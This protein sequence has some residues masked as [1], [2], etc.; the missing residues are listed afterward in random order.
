MSAEESEQQ[1]FTRHLFRT[2]CTCPTKLYYKANPATY[3]EQRNIWPFIAHIRYNKRQLRLLLQRLYP[4]G[5]AVESRAYHDAAEET[6]R[7]LKQN[8]VV[9]FNSTFLHELFAVR[10]PVLEKEGRRVRVYNLQSKVFDPDRHSLSDRNGRIHSRWRKYLRDFSFQLF[11]I[12][13]QFPEWRLEGYLVM[14]DKRGTAAVD[15]LDQ[16]LAAGEPVERDGLS[17]LLAFVPA[18][19]Q[20]EALWEGKEPLFE[21]GNAP[22]GMESL[23]FEEVVCQSARW[24]AGGDKIVTPLG[25]KCANCEYRVDSDKLRKGEKS[26]FE[27]CWQHILENRD[28]E[29][30]IFDLIGAGNGQL[31]EDR[32]FLQQEISLNDKVTPREIAESE[33]RITDLHRRILQVAQARGEPV[34]REIVKP[35]LFRELEKWQYPLHFLDFE[36]GSFAVPLR[37]G[38]N[39]YHQVV[40]QYSCHTL[41]VDGSLVHHQWVHPGRGGY[42]HYQLVSELKKIP[43]FREGTIIHYSGFERSALRRILAEFKEESEQHT[44]YSELIN[45]L[46]TIV[47]DRYSRP[48]MADMGRLLKN[49]YYNEQME[50]SLSIKDILVTVMK[51]SPAVQKRFSTPYHSSNFKNIVWWQCEDGRLRDPYE[52]IRERQEHAIGRGT[53][54]MVAYGQLRTGENGA[55][56]RGQLIDGLLS[57]CELDTLAMVMIYLHWE[58]LLREQ[59]TE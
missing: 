35:P 13:Q 50:D 47:H 29:A 32:V 10:I 1:L 41:H 52:M 4:E 2:A 14:P 40:F 48:L 5:T 17:N 15:N 28:G 36:A 46:E 56:K 12:Q 57:Y 42:A 31:I 55:E 39:P 25:R 58:A 23:S 6:R 22:L 9:L 18:M 38:R 3:P 33:G 8:R 19:E 53:E 34:P 44:E 49:Y 11:V 27:E 21:K 7:R 59:Q 20:I 37:A 43:G 26:G 45:W 30:H 54:A 24:Y 16:M 51:V